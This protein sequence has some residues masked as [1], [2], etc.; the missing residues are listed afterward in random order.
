MHIVISIK[1]KYQKCIL[2]DQYIFFR[3]INVHNIFTTN[4]K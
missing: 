1:G 3:E 2:L 4:L